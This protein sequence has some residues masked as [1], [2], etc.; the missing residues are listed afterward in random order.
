[1]TFGQTTIGGI[2]KTV[3]AFLAIALSISLAGDARNYLQTG[4]MSSLLASEVH[5]V[6]S[7]NTELS[8]ADAVS[9][10]LDSADLGLAGQVGR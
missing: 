2:V 4:E 7:Q 9:K 1:M 6:I 3:T 10:V 5:K 8:V